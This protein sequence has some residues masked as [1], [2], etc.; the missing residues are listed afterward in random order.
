MIDWHWGCFDS[1][2]D[3]SEGVPTSSASREH[4]I[5]HLG[6][7]RCADRFIRAAMPKRNP[8]TKVNRAAG[9]GSN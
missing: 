4:R 1:H 7:D 9:L 5:R 6:V 8:S 2:P 3:Q